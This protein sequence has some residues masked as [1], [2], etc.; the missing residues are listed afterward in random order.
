M[1]SWVTR[2][3]SLVPRTSPSAAFRTDAY[4]PYHAQR[5]DMP[6]D[7]AHQW[8]LAPRLFAAFDW[9]VQDTDSYEADDLMGTLA[10]K[11]EAAGGEA[12]IL[13]GDRDMFQCATEKV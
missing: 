4:P 6:D 9:I 8:A 13:T 11:E 1:S 3:Q 2:C 10:A 12:L 5:P 7:L